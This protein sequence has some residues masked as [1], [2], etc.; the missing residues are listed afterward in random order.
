[1]PREGSN[2]WQRLVAG[3][4]DGLQ[5]VFLKTVASPAA[6]AL[7]AY[8][9]ETLSTHF[10]DEVY[11]DDAK[12]PYLV[13]ARTRHVLPRPHLLVNTDAYVQRTVLCQRY[14]TPP[15]P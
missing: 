15:T 4:E 7:V 14:R 2:D 10:T 5:E 6:S 9:V 13:R 3:G 1:M 11:I 12:Q 8:V